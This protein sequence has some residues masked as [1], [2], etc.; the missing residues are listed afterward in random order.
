[1]WLST[2]TVR[3]VVTRQG[4]RNVDGAV[5][6][7]NRVAP[8]VI[9]R[10]W[11]GAGVSSGWLCVAPYMESRETAA[12]RMFLSDFYLFIFGRNARMRVP[13]K[14]RPY[15]YAVVHRMMTA[16]RVKRTCIRVSMAEG[17]IA[18]VPASP[19][20]GL[21][22]WRHERRTRPAQRRRDEQ[23]CDP[24]PNLLCHRHFLSL[25]PRKH[26]ARPL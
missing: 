26:R 3:P 9:V 14:I 16:S 13:S 21:F 25:L 20:P 17:A 5:L 18:L 12:S 2:A 24:Q 23:R 4:P 22:V 8:F 7:W 19:C 15:S 10:I 6:Q 11:Q 1:M